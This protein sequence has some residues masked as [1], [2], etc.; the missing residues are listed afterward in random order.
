MKRILGI[1]L[2]IFGIIIFTSFLAIGFIANGT[3]LP[4]AILGVLIDYIIVAICVGFIYLVTWL[5]SY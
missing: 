3:S 2:A 1:V 5:L 4:L